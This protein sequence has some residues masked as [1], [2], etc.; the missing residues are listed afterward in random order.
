MTMTAAEITDRA[1]LTDR[2]HEVLRGVGRGHSDPEIAA[3]LHLPEA[4]VGR[5]VD[6]I[7]GKL[8]LRDRGAAI[9]YA[10]DHG[11]VEPTRSTPVVPT[12]VHAVQS[13]LRFALLGTLRAWWDDR[14]MD[15]GPIR[16]Q[17]LLAALLLRPDVTVSRQ[18]LL[19]DVW[20]FEQPAG[21]VAPVYI[22]RLRRC[23]QATEGAADAPII[24]SDPG[25]YRF[26]SQGVGRDVVR[27]D[28]LLATAA[29][30]EQAGDLTGAVDAYTSAL[31]LFHGEP[32]A[33]LPGPFAAGQRLRLAE[34]RTA[35]TLAKLEHQVQ[36]GDHPAAIAELSALAQRHPYH[37]SA[38]ALLMRALHAAGRQADGLAVYTHTRRRL[39][40]DLGVEP[41]PQLRQAHQFVLRGTPVSLSHS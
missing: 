38:A 7:L 18:D 39:V 10:F 30:A 34:R 5:H 2:E 9:V 14:P 32:L 12:A 33:G 1:P 17:A 23:L 37:E 31:A 36:L 13:R 27:W 3:T 6:R 11:I 15:L 35:V 28:Q 25:G 4:T 29:A 22:Y 8:G 20:D 41:G 16:Q 24:V 40:N 21:N 26:V 19:T